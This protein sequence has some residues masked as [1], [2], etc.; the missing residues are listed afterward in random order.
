MYTFCLNP[1]FPG[2]F[3]LCFKAGRDGPLSS[4]GVKVVP[5]AFELKKNPYPDMKAL[6][7]GFKTLMTN[8][9][10]STAGRPR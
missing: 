9:A 10:G 5:N 2:W 4:W 7:N 1:K 8:A 6:K 3:F